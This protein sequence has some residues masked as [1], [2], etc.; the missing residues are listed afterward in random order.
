ME[1]NQKGMD[2][3]LQHIANDSNA[4]LNVR[5]DGGYRPK[6]ELALVGVHIQLSQIGEKTSQYPQRFYRPVSKLTQWIL[7]TQNSWQ[8]EH[9]YIMLPS[10]Q[11]KYWMQ[12]LAET[13]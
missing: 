3:I 13:F 10:W 7:I 9:Q 12:S 11:Q 1:W 6:Q 2:S 8:Q 4:Y 5:F